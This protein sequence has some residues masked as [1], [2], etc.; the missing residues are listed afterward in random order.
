[1]LGLLMESGGVPSFLLFSSSSSAF[2]VGPVYDEVRA[3]PVG[4]IG[5]FPW[6]PRWI[7]L[8][9]TLQQVSR[10]YP[11]R[12]VSD[13]EVLANVSIVV[14]TG[15]DRL[16]GRNHHHFCCQKWVGLEVDNQHHHHPPRREHCE[17]I[18]F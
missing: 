14:V 15:V 1:M 3:L 6:C 10:T 16:R 12:M 2:R 4:F 7:I 18:C 13:D 11:V 9:S 5:I 8:S 17:A